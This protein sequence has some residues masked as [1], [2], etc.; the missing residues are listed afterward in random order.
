MNLT[1]FKLGYSPWSERALWALDHHG[2]ARREREYTPIFGEPGMRL[3]ARRFKGRVTV[4][5]LVSDDGVYQDSLEIARYADAHGSGS[6]LFPGLAGE[7]IATWNARSEEMLGAGRARL[8][9]RIAQSKAAKKDSLKFLPG[10]L[11]GAML[12][13][14]NIGIAYITRK[15]KL[16]PTAQE[17]DLATIRQG[18]IELRGAL[19]DGRRNVLGEVGFS[20]ADITMAVSLQ[21]VEPVAERYIELGPALR[22]C[23]REPSLSQEFSDLVEWRDEIYA[24]HRRQ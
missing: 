5:L 6:P 8:T 1:L 16:D 18:L 11:R 13:L 4:P 20:Y 12:P 22:E 10:P 14:A 7:V 9:S 15:Y 23:W 17:A 19:A 2:L 24:K 21:V 3:K